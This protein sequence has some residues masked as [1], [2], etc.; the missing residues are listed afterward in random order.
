M[1]SNGPSIQTGSRGKVRGFFS[2]FFLHII[3]LGIYHPVWW[4]KVSNEVN[5]FLGTPRMS[6]AKIVFLS[7][8]TFGLYFLIWQFGDGRKIIQEVQS[9][10]GLPVKAPFIVG[11]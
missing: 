2:Y 4:F 8:L 7:P 3:T 5:A 10:A 11:P 9:R 6:A 1:V